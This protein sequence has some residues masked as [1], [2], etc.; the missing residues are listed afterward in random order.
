[1]STDFPIVCDN[2]CPEGAEGHHKFSCEWA[3]IDGPRY[4][5][6]EVPITGQDGNVF[7]IIGRVTGA[8]RKAGHADQ[9]KNFTNHI[10]D[11]GS[12]EDALERVGTWV[13]TT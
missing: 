13:S 8:L 7:F 11:A 3:T 10:T 5:E 12:Y 6:I 1:M 4:P 9:I 2:G